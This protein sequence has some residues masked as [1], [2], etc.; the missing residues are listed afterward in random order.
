[1][2]QTRSQFANNPLYDIKIQKPEKTQ[3][4]GV[5]F[6]ANIANFAYT[7]FFCSYPCKQGAIRQIHALDWLTCWNNLLLPSINNYRVIS[8]TS[9]P[10]YRLQQMSLVIHN[11]GRIVWVIRNDRR[12]LCIYPLTHFPV[13]SYKTLWRM[14]NR[15]RTPHV[16]LAFEAT[17]STVAWSRWGS[18]VEGVE[19]VQA[20]FFDLSRIPVTCKIFICIPR[21]P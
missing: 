18:M 21:T 19:W 17:E 6:L 14:R 7:G 15:K 20:M 16:Q 10:S 8:D 13:L 5:H 11:T 1:M 9:D 3:A 4:F 12:R 2:Y